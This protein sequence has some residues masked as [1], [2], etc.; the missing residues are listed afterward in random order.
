MIMALAITISMPLAVSALV[1]GKATVESVRDLDF[2]AAVVGVLM[3]A[4][5]LGAALIAWTAFY[6]FNQRSLLNGSLVFRTGRVGREPTGGSRL[7]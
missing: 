4:A 7:A 2:E 3:L 5:I 1:I 6:T